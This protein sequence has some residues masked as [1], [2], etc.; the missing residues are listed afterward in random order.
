MSKFFAVFVTLIALTAVGISGF[1]YYQAWLNQPLEDTDPV[2][3]V[4][5][6]DVAGVAA[7]EGDALFEL[8]SLDDGG[9]TQML[10]RCG[11]LLAGVRHDYAGAWTALTGRALVDPQSGSLRAGELHVAVNAMRGDGEHPAPNA[12]INTVR[13]NQWFAPEHPTAVLSTTAAR[14]RAAEE[15]AEFD[16]AVDGWT[17]ALACKLRLNGVTKDM[18]VYARIEIGEGRLHLDAAFAISRSLFSVS[19]R[20]GFE[21]PAEVDD[22]VLVDVR[23][24][25]TPDPLAVVAELNREL[26]SQQARNGVLA[27]QVDTLTARL[28][29]VESGQAELLRE[30]QAL[31]AAGARAGAAAALDA[32][33]LPARFTDY[34]DY[35]NARG[36]EQVLDLGYEAEF[37]MVLIPGDPAKDIQ[38]FYAQTTEVTWQMFRA[39]SY[40]TDLEDPAYAAEMKEQLLRPTPCYEDASRG[41]GFEGTAVLGVSRRNAEAFCK[42]VSELTGRSYRL[43]TDAEWRYVAEA[44][45]GVPEDLHAV[46]WLDGNCRE[47]EWGAKMTMPVAKKPA[48]KLGLHDFWGNVAEWVMDDEV[49]IRG[50]S[51]LVGK[52]DLTMDWRE[53]ESQD[54]W[55]ETYPNLPKS[56]WWYRDRFDMGFRLV[57]DPINLPDAK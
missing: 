57:C 44:T 25:A 1:A 2:A 4:E 41:H 7:A 56:L 37:E 9:N 32:S 42:H 28:D 23:V 6:G 12:M 34:V 26:V 22:E 50:G 54:I 52:D 17:H 40:C 53:T 51:Y 13:A 35:Q 16:G 21:P 18:T 45:G 30:L 14:P 20:R 55:N 15:A 48:N 3:P 8:T 46:A 29:R 19:K 36:D 43:W 39:W 10:W 5:I 11:K 47:D 38:P 33:T 31:K 49:F 24:R 27:Q